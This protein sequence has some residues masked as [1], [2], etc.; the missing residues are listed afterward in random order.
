METVLLDKFNNVKQEVQQC[1]TRDLTNGTFLQSRLEQQDTKQ[2]YQTSNCTSFHGY[3]TGKSRLHTWNCMLHKWKSK[4]SEQNT[5]IFSAIP[6]V[7][8]VWFIK[9]SVSM[10]HTTIAASTQKQVI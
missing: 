10:Y 7:K 6:Y 2:N 3:T 4:P 9:I 8:C 5:K 1:N